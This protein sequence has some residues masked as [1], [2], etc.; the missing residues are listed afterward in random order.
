M[1][2]TVTDFVMTWLDPIGVVIGL[3]VTLPV[4]WTWYEV[5]VG[6]RRRRR[7]WF[8]E[9]RRHAGQRPAILIVDLLPD[10]DIRISVEHFRTAYPPLRAIPDDRIF[11]VSRSRAVCS[12][13]MPGLQEEFRLTAGRLIACGADRVHYF[14]AGPAIAAAMVGAEFANAV[15]V[16]LYQRQNGG[17]EN[18][19]PLRCLS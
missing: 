12:D 15:P 2:Q 3:L 6:E 5:V 13:D 7:R 10:R 9:T 14:H 11:V 1:W 16:Y 17:Y 19:G 18:F 8:N 4:F